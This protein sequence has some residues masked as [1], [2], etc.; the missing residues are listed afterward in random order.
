MAGQEEHT[1]H[2]TMLHRGGARWASDQSDGDTCHQ[3]INN[4]AIVN[5][6]DKSALHQPP[7]LTWK[8]L[9]I[10]RR[11]KKKKMPPKLPIADDFPPN[12]TITISYPGSPDTTPPPTSTSA[13]NILILLHGL[14]DTATKFAS[15]GRALNLPETICIT[16]Q[17]PTPLP[18]SFIDIPGGGFHWGDDVVFNNDNDSRTEGALAMDAGFDRARRLL[19][20]DVITDTLVRKCGYK[21]RDIMLLGFGQGG[22]AALDAARELGLH[23]PVE[24][25]MTVAASIESS[26][27]STWT[28]SSA[29]ARE[30]RGK[31]GDK[32]YYPSL[33]GVVSFGAAYPLSAS[34]LG[35]KDRTPVLLLAGRDDGFSAVTDTALKRTRDIFEFVEIHRWNRRGDGM[36]RS[37][38]DMLP[39]MQFF[40]RRLQSRKGV[41]DGA[42]ELT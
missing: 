5:S 34:T 23:P 6:L 10:L 18:S 21:L 24:D 33:S 30:G 11:Q 12:A 16:V 29:S 17:G 41:P 32:S 15:F 35:P 13:H 36:P 7:P 27:E 37:R 2:N 14:G 19:V 42:I 31:I 9:T 26:T 3:L 22:M 38:E 25:E 40:A 4:Q 28:P 20:K 1:S 8:P 39:V